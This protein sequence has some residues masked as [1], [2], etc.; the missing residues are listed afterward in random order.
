MPSLWIL[1]IVTFLGTELIGMAVK[2]LFPGM[3]TA[4][5]ELVE[6]LLL[7]QITDLMTDSKLTSEVR[8]RQYSGAD[9]GPCGP[10]L[11]RSDTCSTNSG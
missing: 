10:C 3:F 4:F 8:L 7:T 6:R 5:Q 9:T 2:S 1:K 11:S